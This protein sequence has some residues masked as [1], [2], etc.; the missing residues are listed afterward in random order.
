MK[1]NERIK[2][3][4]LT[5]LRAGK[6]KQGHGKLHIAGEN[7][8]CCLGVLTKLYIKECG[9]K[10]DFEQAAWEVTTTTKAERTDYLWNDFEG[11]LTPEVAKWA[12]LR[13]KNRT[14]PEI[15]GYSLSMHNDGAEEN[16]WCGRDEI[17]RK[18][19]NEIADLI[20]KNL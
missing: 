17:P 5:A 20:E 13:G 8:Y 4:W 1:M 15:K 12:G 7:K 2:E 6:I 16:T 11:C 9:A 14:D 3:V 19:F 18:T 10:V